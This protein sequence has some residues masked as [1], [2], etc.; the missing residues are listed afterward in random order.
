[1]KKGSTKKKAPAS[2]KA[3]ADAPPSAADSA[4]A[5]SKLEQA[6]IALLRQEPFYA[7]LLTSLR[8]VYSTEVPTAAVSAT[9]RG[10]TL[11]V[12][13]LFFLKQISERERIGVLKHELLHLMFKHPWRETSNMPDAIL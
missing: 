13:P 6:A 8:R 3:K 11:W 1:M 4:A 2:E 9:G 5:A 12:N 10:A 7:H